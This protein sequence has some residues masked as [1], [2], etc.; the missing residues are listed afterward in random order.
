[1]TP[2]EFKAAYPE[3]D[4][5]TDAQV[6]TWLDDFALLY[7]ADYGALEDKLTG[8]YTAHQLVVYVRRTGSS[9]VQRATSRSVD[10]LS[11]SYADSE[12]AQMAGDF[13]STKYGMEFARLI[14]FFGSGP[15]MAA[16]TPR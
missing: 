5:L 10:G 2:A 8:L 15:T 13:G 4:D 6:Q 9:P 7:Q 11:W 16:A 14:R 3:F 12:S 1:M